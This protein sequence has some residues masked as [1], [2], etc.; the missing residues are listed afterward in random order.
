MARTPRRINLSPGTTTDP[1]RRLP[2]VDDPQSYEEEE[3]ERTRLTNVPGRGPMP[4]RNLDPATW[5]GGR[6]TRVYDPITPLPE[7]FD[8]VE[9]PENPGDIKG[10]A[11]ATLVDYLRGVPVSTSVEYEDPYELDPLLSLYGSAE[12]AEAKPDPWAW[13]AGYEGLH[14]LQRMA[15]EGF[16]PEELETIERMGQMQDTSLRGGELASQEEQARMGIGTAATD[17]TTQLNAAQAS[18]Q[19][20]AMRD[21]ETAAAAEERKRFAT[22]AAGQLGADLASQSFQ[23]DYMRGQARDVAARAEAEARQKY[24]EARAREE[25]T[26]RQAEIDLKEEKFKLQGQGVSLL[27][28]WQATDRRETQAEEADRVQGEASRPHEP[29]NLFQGVTTVAGL[30][31]D[32]LR[33]DAEAEARKKREEEEAAKATG[34]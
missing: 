9:R 4:I 31:A 17:L 34:A 21:I 18:A 25:E 5:I 2:Q 27:G 33:A 26:R 24:E 22:T 7:G 15:D 10:I 6:G 13:Y 8:G 32:Y 3:K 28:D 16:L 14:N 12:A 20:A 11:E 19:Q 30:G 1:L 29:S 23:Q